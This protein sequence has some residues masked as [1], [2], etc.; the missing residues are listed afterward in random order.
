[1][2]IEFFLFRA[3][4]WILLIVFAIS[5]LFVYRGL[6]DPAAVHFDMDGQPDGFLPKT[7]IFYLLGGIVIL[8][9]I[10]VGTVAKL[11]LKVPISNEFLKSKGQE[12]VRMVFAHFF[13]FFLV[14]LNAYA[15]YITRVLIMT[16]DSRTSDTDYSYLGSMALVF[17]LIWLIYPIA[18]IIFM[19]NKIS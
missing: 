2:S 17:I 9:N 4:K 8:F 1:M 18:R 12:E 19:P 15:A 10:L 3:L 14:L 13:N 7:Q 6:P 5:L 11:V 16:N